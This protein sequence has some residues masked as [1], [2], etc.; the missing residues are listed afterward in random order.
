MPGC[1]HPSYSESVAY[2]WS[3]DGQFYRAITTYYCQKCGAT[4]DVVYGAWCRKA[5]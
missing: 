2:E 5:W 3:D 1:D 4:I